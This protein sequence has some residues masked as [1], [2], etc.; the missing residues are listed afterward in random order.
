MK[1]KAGEN[2]LRFLLFAA[3]PLNEPVAWGGPIVMNNEIELAKA[4][5]ELQSGD[6]IKD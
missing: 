2:G 5:D 1:V 4:F 3:K 6:F